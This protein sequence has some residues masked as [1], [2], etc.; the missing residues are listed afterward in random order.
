MYESVLFKRFFGTISF[1]HTAVITI[2]KPEIIWVIFTR[3]K[4]ERLSLFLKKSVRNK[5]YKFP[6]SS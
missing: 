4:M 1:E 3:E 6:L 2:R 5:N